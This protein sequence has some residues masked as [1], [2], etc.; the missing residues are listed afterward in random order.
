MYYRHISLEWPRQTVQV[1]C[2][3]DRP[4]EDTEIEHM[5][6]TIKFLPGICIATKRDIRT[7]SV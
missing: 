5:D 2:Q 6:I 1:F 3:D 7:L 4:V